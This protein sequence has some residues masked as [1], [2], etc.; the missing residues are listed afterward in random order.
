MG[1]GA[2]RGVTAAE[3]GALIDAVLAGAGLS[4]ARVRAVATADAK[5]DEAG[6]LAAARERGW[7]VVAY[8]A[9]ALAAVD[10]PHPGERVRAATGTPSVAEAAALHCAAEA[11][12]GGAD[13]V[14][15]KRASAR[16]TVAVAREGGAEATGAVSAAR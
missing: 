13:L 5:A 9:A 16:A 6:I 4:P 10:V 15:G 7:P 14:A 8:P 11:G 1:V 3:V 2:R 12:G